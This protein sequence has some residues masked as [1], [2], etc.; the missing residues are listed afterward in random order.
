MNRLFDRRK[1]NMAS[2]GQI[3]LLERFGHKHAAG[4]SFEKA[5][6]TIDAIARNGWR[7][8]PQEKQ[9]FMVF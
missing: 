2:P 8:L 1:M 3:G 9:E 5:K 4:M 7:P 6:A